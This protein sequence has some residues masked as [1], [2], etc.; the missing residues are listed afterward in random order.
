MPNMARLADKDYDSKHRYFVDGSPV[1]AE[2]FDGSS[3][4]T[5][6]VGGL[7]AGGRGYFALNITNPKD[8]KVLWEFGAEQSPNLGLTFGNPI[9]AKIPDGRWAVIFAS[10]YNNGESQSNGDKNDPAGDGVG[11]IFIL[12]ANTG[13][14]I[15]E[16]TTGVGD[17]TTPSGLGKING[18]VDKGYED[19]TGGCPVRS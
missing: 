13:K 6:L 14:P 11:R 12:D 3:W 5:I 9:V 4:K 15:H 19:N 7:G 16:M 1:A 10:G 18:W 2:I 17:P 8:P